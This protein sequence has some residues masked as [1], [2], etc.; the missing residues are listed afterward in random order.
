MVIVK[1]AA[2]PRCQHSIKVSV[3]QLPKGIYAVLFF[4]GRDKNAKIKITQCP[5]CKADL[6]Q[7]S[8]LKTM[9]GLESPQLG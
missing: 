5:A 7:S 2:C 6:F 8:I 9:T 1:T 4:D 3:K